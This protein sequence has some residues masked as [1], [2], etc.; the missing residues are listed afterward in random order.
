[1]DH[2]KRD[3]IQ[4]ELLHTIRLEAGEGKIDRKIERVTN[5]GVSSIVKGLTHSE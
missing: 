1:V 5:G 4:K 2:A 3:A